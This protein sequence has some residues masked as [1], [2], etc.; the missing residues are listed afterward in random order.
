[1]FD[2]WMAGVDDACSYNLDQPL[3]TRNEESK[4]ITVNFD[5]QVIFIDNN[6][7]IHSWHYTTKT[8]KSAFD[9]YGNIIHRF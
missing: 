4:L 8:N 3:I 9:A 2:E 5:P 6:E 7:L 1:M